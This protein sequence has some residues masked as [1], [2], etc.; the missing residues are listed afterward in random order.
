MVTLLSAAEQKGRV[1]DFHDHFQKCHFSI[2]RWFTM[3][4]RAFTNDLQPSA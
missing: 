4:S 3:R 1:D 2:T